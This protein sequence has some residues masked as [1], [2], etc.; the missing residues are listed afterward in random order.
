MFT[1]IKNANNNY[2]NVRKDLPILLLSGKDDPVSNFGKSIIDLNNF[3]KKKKLTNVKY[4]IYNGLRHLIFDETE[5]V[6]VINDLVQYINLNILN[7]T[8]NK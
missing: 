5:K 6:I 1:L 7:K 3:Y 4:K 2:K 8:E